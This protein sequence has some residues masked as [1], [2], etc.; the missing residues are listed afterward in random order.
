MPSETPLRV[1]LIGTGIFASQRHFPAIASIP[2][3][4]QLA[5]CANRSIDKAKK[6]ASETGIPESHVYDSL[7]S[8]LSD[9]NVD[10][11]DALLPSQ[12]SLQAVKDAISAGKPIAIEKPIAANLA[13][14]KEI[15]AI[16]RS[17]ELPVAVLENFIFWNVIPEIKSLIEQIGD[18]VYFSHYCTSPFNFNNQYLETWWRQK[19]EHVGGFLSD[20]GVHQVALF[21]EILGQVDTLSALTTQV[22]EQS[23]DVDTLTATLKM[24]SGVLGSFTYTSAVSNPRIN[25]LSINGTKGTVIYD[26]SD[27]AS[28]T[29]MLYT[30]ADKTG[31][32]IPVPDNVQEGVPKEFENFAEAVQ[33]NDKSLLKI[34]PEKAFHHFAVIVASV[35]SSKN[36]G[37]SVKVAE[38]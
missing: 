25:K 29:L 9:P 5:A 12:F 6:F 13:Q 35:E 23:G 31:K 19:P 2:S 16:A 7:A 21:T 26:F 24:K 30:D 36:G 33:K 10:V 17:T 4:V 38:P 11:I 18:V 28:A 32:V 8:L 1:G 34:P 22:R 37:T 20:G 15:V 3:T 14:A 27:K